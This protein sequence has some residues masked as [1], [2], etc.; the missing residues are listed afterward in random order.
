MKRMPTTILR[1]FLVF[2]VIATA[3]VG[4]PPTIAYAEG[5]SITDTPTPIATGGMN[6]WAVGGGLAYWANHCFAEEFAPDSVLNRVPIAGGPSRTVLTVDAAFCN[7]FYS[8]AADGSGVY[9]VNDFHDASVA[10]HIERIPLSEPFTPQPI[11]ELPEASKP[12]FGSRATPLRLANGFIYW[13]STNS[14]QVLRVAKNGGAIET[15]V[16]TAPFPSDLL[17]VGNTVY[18]TDSTGVWSISIN[19][20][21]LPCID[22]KSPFSPFAAN[23]AGSGLLYRTFTGVRNLTFYELFWVERSGGLDKIRHRVCSTIVICSNRATTFYDGPSNTVL[24]RPVTDGTSL[25]WTELTF[26]PSAPD[27]KIRR[28]PLSTANSAVD[29]ATNQIGIDDQMAIV[30]GNLYFAVAGGF[31]PG[32]YQLPLNA[33][34]ILRDLKADFV[35]VTQGIQNA[36]N[37]APLAA[38]K[39][40]YVRAYA[41]QLNGPNA[42][43]VEARLIGTRNES[44]LPGSPLAPVNG[45]RNLR[46]GGSHDRI[47]ANDSWN[48]RLPQSWTDA[49]AITLR[50]VV[51][52]RSYHTDPNRANNE[53][54]QDIIFQNQPPVCVVSVPVRTHTPLPTANDPFVSNM[55]DH[56][57]R[58][59]PIPDVWRYRMTDPVEELQVCW[60]GPFPYPCYGPYELE[61]GWGITNGPPDR[62]KVIASL[63]ARAQLSFNPDACD[64]IN[65]PVHFMGLVHPDANN[66]GASGYAST[67]SNQSWVQ[68]PT[69]TPKPNVNNWNGLRPGSVMAQEL[70]HNFGRKHIDCGNPD[71]VD[72][73]YPYPPC[74]LDNAGQSNYYGFDGATQTPIAPTQAADFMSYASGGTWVSDYTWRALYNDFAVTAAAAGGPLDLSA[75]NSVFVVGVVD[76]KTNQGQLTTMLVLP[77]ASVPPATLQA[78]QMQAAQVDDPQAVFRLRLLDQSGKVLV[79][80]TLK[81]N[82]FDDHRPE[83][84]S[85]MF[86]DLFAPPAGKVATVQLLAGNKVIDSLTPGANPPTLS[87]QQPTGSTV[88]D[89]SL[90]V[91]WTASD[92]DA[93]DALTFVVQYS[94]DN[95][96]KWQTLVNDFP[97]SP[98]PVN[99]L[100]LSD[101]GSLPGSNGKNARIRVLASD[102]Y[103]TAIALSQ[104]FTVKNRPPEPAISSPASGEVFAADEPVILHGSALDPETG[105]VS[106]DALQWSIDGKA[107]G[108]GPDVEVNGLAPGVHSAGLTAT[109]PASAVEAASA[110]AGNVPFTI[111]ALSIPITG[112]PQLNGFCDD[113]AYDDGVT[114][115]LAPYADGSQATV[116]LVRDL[117]FLWACFAGMNKGATVPGAFAGLRV[118]VDSSRDELAQ[119]SDFGFFVG[120]DGSVMTQKGDGAGNFGASAPGGFQ[121]QVSAGPT[122]WSGE[123]RINANLLGGWGHLV[124]INL[125]HYWAAF[126]GDDYLWPYASVWNKPNSWAQTALGNMPVVT[127]L[128]PITA[129]VGSAAF[130]M[131]VE[132][133]NFISGT[134]ALWNG[135][136]LST[137]VVDEGHLAVKVEKP[138]LAVVGVVQVSAR[139]G[140]LTSNSV[141]FAVIKKRPVITS[142]TPD[143]T[144]AGSAALEI[145]VVGAN[146]AAGSQLLWDGVALPTTVVNSKTLKVQIDVGRLAIGQVANLAVRTPA[147]DEQVSKPAP[148]VV[149]P[150]NQQI[151][152]PMVSR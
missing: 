147:P 134:T 138:K 29:I 117:N 120:E 110:T 10:S 136:P 93:G 103:N 1:L 50:L 61:D 21:T 112:T 75:A 86:S 145:T 3:V 123:L 81:L 52:P 13:V 55:F 25:F 130:T 104:P 73:N 140:S 87:I 144:N 38:R 80:R 139:F 149:Q 33:S 125:G 5:D 88:V 31:T 142:V 4:S 121:A 72:S 85:A 141:P 6:D 56:F 148:F 27:G 119:T 44:P 39:T 151:F 129:T 22:T 48:F 66:G 40:T 133:S 122:L 102:G 91:Q 94:H 67:I 53:V 100:T 132:G 46:T 68:L 79:T 116:F 83:A 65:A 49:G 30:N 78:A 28:N 70:A 60:K 51:D 118:D 41:S 152:L 98:D 69:H 62:D 90:T 32:I 115:Q 89:S 64:D 127:G 76:Q 7:T 54:P 63:W 113:G 146:F 96:A 23:T 92:P 16:D 47:N 105:G 26:Q 24:G 97:G 19:C 2:A 17:V 124:G 9:Y 108:A 59:W 20:A 15:V 95:G 36:A 106:A 37:G 42:V 71:D 126:Q 131:T 107:V 35:E 128:D 58:R 45:N 82:E 109:D 150:M 101:I 43:N 135:T 114:L 11:V 14:T 18:W 99:T 137:T 8:I 34:A 74:Q 111:A 143:R 12:P 77:T 57:L 84:D